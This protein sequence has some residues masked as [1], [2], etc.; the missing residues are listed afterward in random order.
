MNDL[1]ALIRACKDDPDDDRARLVLSDWLEEHGDV[2][3]AEFIRLQCG[4][5]YPVPADTYRLGG[6]GAHG[7]WRIS[8]RVTAPR[9]PYD[10]RNRQREA[11]LLQR[12]RERWLDVPASGVFDRGFLTVGNGRGLGRWLADRPA[13]EVAWIDALWVSFN[14]RP[15]ST[16]R[17]L[18]RGPLLGGL[19]WLSLGAGDLHP[20]DIGRQGDPLPRDEF[21]ALLEYPE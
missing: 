1:L 14:S 9:P 2:E 18:S 13:E 16:L 10:E 5:N 20:E 7:P 4:A 19:V 8:E 6:F 21:R 3:R 15:G 11:E 12:N 17:E